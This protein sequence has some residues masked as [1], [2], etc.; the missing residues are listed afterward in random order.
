MRYD[1][2][3]EEQ[4]DEFVKAEEFYR[5]VLFHEW[6]MDNS[7]NEWWEI[8][9]IKP[10]QILVFDDDGEADVDDTIEEEYDENGNHKTAR[11]V[12]VFN[13]A[14]E[15]HDFYCDKE[16]EQRN[17]KIAGLEQERKLF[18]NSK[19]NTDFVNALRS[20]KI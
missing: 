20:Q 15:A 17:E 18:E 3:T 6:H 10:E 16:I 5:V 13:D 14:Q 12:Y 8:Q 4:V 2:I 9:R 11:D 7:E 1:E 19:K